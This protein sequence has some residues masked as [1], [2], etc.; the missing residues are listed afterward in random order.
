M[1]GGERTGLAKAA[2]YVY[3][4]NMGQND[5]S[6]NIEKMPENRASYHHGDLRA[7]LIAA[8]LAALD[9]PQ[10]ADM[11]SLRALA[12]ETGV[13]A[14]AVYR[15]FPDKAA[16]LTALS[17]AGLDAMATAQD[18]AASAAGA[19]GADGARARFCASGAAYVR[20][21][22]AHPALFRLMWRQDV[23]CD[24][25]AQ[26]IEANHPAMAAL[27]RGIDALLPDAASLAERRAAALAAWALVHGLSMLALDGQINLADSEIDA[28]VAGHFDRQMRG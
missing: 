14:T 12:R 20:F 17:L 9:S 2:F 3:T 10:S 21:A 18:A 19:G 4:I 15:H 22:L 24:P 11:L 6:V 7:A 1:E 8:G 27:R 25:L 5:N 13:S 26:P 16:L 28:V 23:A